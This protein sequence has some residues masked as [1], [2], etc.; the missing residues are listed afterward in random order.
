MLTLNSVTSQVRVKGDELTLIEDLTA[1]FYKGQL[2]AIVGPSGCG[3][4]SFIK[5]IAGLNETTSGQ[6]LW[7]NQDLEEKD[8]E[9]NEL[10]Y[11]PQFSIACEELTVYENVSYAARLRTK[12]QG[13]LDE[14]LEEILTQTG[15][16]ELSDKPVKVL[17]GGQK[18]RLSLA[19]E[20]TANP[21]ILLCDEVTSGLDINSERQIVELLKSLATEQNRLILSVTHSL[22]NIEAYDAIVVLYDGVLVYHGHPNTILPY[23][24]ARD[25]SGIYHQLPSLEP[26]QWKNFWNDLKHEYSV[27]SNTCLDDHEERKIPNPLSQTFTLLQRRWAIFFR[28]KGQVL[29]NLILIIG[30]PLIIILFSERGRDP[31]RKLSETKDQNIFLELLNK[32][33]VNQDLVTVGSA[34]SGIIMFQ[35][36]LL[37]L[38]GSNNSAREIAGERQIWEK[39]RLAGVRPSSYL[40]SKLI[41]LGTLIFIQSSVM[42][43]LVEFFWPFRGDFIQHWILLTLVNATMTSICLAISSLFKNASQA[44]LI[45]IYLVGFQLPLSGAIL[46]LPHIPELISRP[47]ISAYWAWS[48]SIDSLQNNINTAVQTVSGTSLSNIESSYLVLGT[49]IVFGIILASIGINRT[50][51]K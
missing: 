7:N 36:I 48:G 39:E 16:L 25:T 15:L 11:V 3:K 38:T 12:R 32:A 45:S 34:V 26:E 18:R 50:Y 43:Y 42:A 51:I 1:E 31:I 33:A 19:I 37:C 23:F 41:Y 24:N 49:H 10:G 21:D 29:I 28:D 14:Y 44:S 8:F 5:T 30:F 13:N 17:S 27:S 46:T 4:T 40:M 2:I 9:P 6:I 47:F 20:L 22:E 35:I